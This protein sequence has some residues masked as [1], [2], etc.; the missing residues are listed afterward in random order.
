MKIGSDQSAEAGQMKRVR[1]SLIN[2]FPIDLTFE[3]AGILTGIRL[4]PVRLCGRS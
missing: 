1:Q 3:D 2:G 4:A